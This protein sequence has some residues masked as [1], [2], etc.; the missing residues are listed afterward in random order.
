MTVIAP[1]SALVPGAA[2]WTRM[3]AVVPPARPRGESS[4]ISTPGRSTG[5]GKGTEL[6]VPLRPAPRYVR[7]AADLPGQGSGPVMAKPIRCFCRS[8]KQKAK[9]AL[10]MVCRG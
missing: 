1:A 8:P 10:A 5:H 6:E 9:C 4:P 7:E 2:P 3:T